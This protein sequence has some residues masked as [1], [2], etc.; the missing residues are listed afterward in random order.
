MYHIFT[1]AIYNMIVMQTIDPLGSID[2]PNLYK[3]VVY[4]ILIS[5]YFCL[6]ITRNCLRLPNAGVVL[7]Q[8]YESYT[9]TERG[10]TDIIMRATGKVHMYLPD[11]IR[12]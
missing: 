4:S 8:S 9:L 1:A 7:S 5:I 2:Q 10:P 11:N 3:Y 12:V 6:K